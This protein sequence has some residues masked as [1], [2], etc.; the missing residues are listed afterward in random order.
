MTEITVT[1]Y[2]GLILD[3]QED[4]GEMTTTAQVFEWVEYIKGLIHGFQIAEV[5]T[6]D[7]AQELEGS[8]KAAAYD[9]LVVLSGGS[10]R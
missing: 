10:A 7:D 1:Q 6:T 8:V 4:L 3:K 2:T 9:R 5:I